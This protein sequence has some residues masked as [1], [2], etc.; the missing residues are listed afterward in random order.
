MAAGS[1]VADFTALEATTGVS[2][3][4]WFLVTSMGYGRYVYDSAGTAAANGDITRVHGAGGRWYASG[5]IKSSTAPTGAAQLFVQVC[6]QATGSSGD[7]ITEIYWN[8]GGGSTSWT[9]Q[10]V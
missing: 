2:D 6:E 3:N 5:V 8:P 1:V 7:I 9:S 10:N 4:D